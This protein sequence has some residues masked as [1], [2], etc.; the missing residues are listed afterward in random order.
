ME[1]TAYDRGFEN[2]CYTK[3]PI[4]Q[5]PYAITSP[6]HNEFARGELDGVMDYDRCE[7]DRSWDD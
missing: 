3:S 4:I 7:S 2:T 5:N 6:N 1:K